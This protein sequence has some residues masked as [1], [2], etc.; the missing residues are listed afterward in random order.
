MTSR[1][2]SSFP[3]YAFNIKLFPDVKFPPA[4]SEAEKASVKE[5]RG[6]RIRYEITLT[7]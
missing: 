5:E 3:T 4:V 7:N 1:N 2:F 6:H